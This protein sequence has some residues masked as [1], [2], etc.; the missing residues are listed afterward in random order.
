[1]R[2]FELEEGEAYIVQDDD[3]DENIDPD[4][5]FSYI[6]QKI[7]NVLGQYQKDFMGGLSAE[8][9]GARFGGYGSFLPMQQRSPPILSN[10]RSQNHVSSKSPHDLPSERFHQ[11]PT[12]A[13]NDSLPARSIPASGDQSVETMSE[14]GISSMNNQ[15]RFQNSGEFASNH[16]KKE[17]V[18]H[19]SEK[20]TLK[21]RVKMASENIASLDNSAI[22]SGLGLVMSPSTSP[23]DSPSE[24]D[25][26][27]TGL[28][29]RNLESPSDILKIMTTLPIPENDLLSPLHGSLLYIKG[30]EKNL[31]TGLPGM[32]EALPVNVVHEN[33]YLKGKKETKKDRRSKVKNASKVKKSKHKEAS[34]ER[35][36]NYRAQIQKPVELKENVDHPANTAALSATGSKDNGAFRVTD[37]VSN[38]S[39]NAVGAYTEEKK[40]ASMMSRNAVSKP[41]TVFDRKNEIGYLGE[42]IGN[43]MKPVLVAR[44]KAKEEPSS[45]KKHDAT[46]DGVDAITLRGKTEKDINFV[47]R[48][49]SSTEKK[50]EVG[51]RG[52][53]VK[54]VSKQHNISKDIVKGEVL[55]SAYLIDKNVILVPKSESSTEK[56]NEGRRES[57]VNTLLKEQSRVKDKVKEEPFDSACPLEAVVYSKGSG[58]VETVPK[59][60]DI[61]F[62]SVKDD[63]NDKCNDMSQEMKYEDVETYETIKKKSRSREMTRS[64]TEQGLPSDKENSFSVVKKKTKDSRIG[65]VPAADSPGGCSSAAKHGEVIFK[66]NTPNKSKKADTDLHREMRMD[67]EVVAKANS[68]KKGKEVSS[69]DSVMG[70]SEQETQSFKRKLKDKSSSIK[71]SLA[72]NIGTK[73][74]A[75][76]PGVSCTTE[77]TPVGDM[78]LAENAPM[79]TVED[80]V[81][82]EKC[83]KWRLLPLGMSA[84][85]LTEKIWTCSMVTWLPGMNKCSFSEDETT[86]A[87]RALYVPIYPASVA[88]TD[89]PADLN[90]NASVNVSAGALNVL[91][92]R[93]T[94][95]DSLPS[96]GK[97]KNLMKTEI[98]AARQIGVQDLHIPVKKDHQRLG[99]TRNLK[100]LKKLPQESDSVRKS[101]DGKLSKTVRKRLADNDVY[102][103]PK[104]L[105]R[106]HQPVED[107]DSGALRVPQGLAKGSSKYPLVKAKGRTQGDI[108]SKGVEIHDV[109]GKKRK[110][111]DNEQRVPSAVVPSGKGGHLVNNLDA[112]KNVGIE[113][114]KEKKSKSSNFQGRESS[115]DRGHHKTQS[116]DAKC[117]LGGAG[118]S[119]LHM[120]GRSDNMPMNQYHV[121][122]VSRRTPGNRISSE[123]VLDLGL[124]DNATTSSSSKIS[125]KVKAKVHEVKSSP[126]GSISSSPIKVSKPDPDKGTSKKSV[127]Y[128]EQWLKSGAE[129]A[130]NEFTPHNEGS[131]D[132]KSNLSRYSGILSDAANEDHFG[133]KVSSGRHS[134]THAIDAQPK[135]EDYKDTSGKLDPTH[136]GTSTS[137]QNLVAENQMTM[138][139]K[140]SHLDGTKSEKGKSHVSRIDSEKEVSSN[141]HGVP[142]FE[143][144]SDSNGGR[145]NNVTGKPSRQAA[146]GHV[147]LRESH[148]IGHVSNDIEASSSRKKDSFH[149]AAKTALREATDLKHS[150]N[151]LKVAGSGLESTGIFFQ[152]ALKFLHGASLLEPGN[153]ESRNGE[154]TPDEVYTSTARLC[155]Y[156][157]LEYEKGNDMASAAL[158]YKCMEV[159]YMRVVYCNDLVASRDRQELQMAVRAAPQVES[160][161]SS[162]SDIDNLNQAAIDTV[163]DGHFAMDHRSHIVSAGNRPN[164]VRLL[165][166]TYDINLAMDA[167]RKSQR[168][169]AAAMPVFTQAGN[170]EGISSIKSVLDF[171]FHDVDGLLH[172]VRLAMESIKP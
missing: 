88:L 44:H 150:A 15:F 75:N 80:W 122:R 78:P 100:N 19:N 106:E 26:I 172:L 61:C 5:D 92:S 142:E 123:M 115:A 140:K 109:S 33:I 84:K 114:S 2:K 11:N 134:S 91:P 171:S 83:H 139:P 113:Y 68:R 27:S 7:E 36:S 164:F 103:V 20:N 120:G 28:Q 136:E 153:N 121:D 151:R 154:M 82:C 79:L 149:R 69:K 4:R 144:G 32:G 3:D 50:D 57:A 127:S 90:A 156:C 81:E 112:G 168:A 21:F 25:G 104:K 132:R 42:D 97:R 34:E 41:S 152:A 37:N 48:N 108:T 17:S 85:S 63:E 56:R 12:V 147:S 66:K 107:Y 76:L 73:V 167:S 74:E 46:E 157:A 49:D 128:N 135:F 40:H 117:N 16:Q 105:K 71:T 31:E 163:K 99:E 143:I 47:L 53:E 137:L 98:D 62:L 77:K 133:K 158:A 29:E 9:L 24:N 138:S 96:G 146:V 60:E 145:V 38:A 125:C 10:Q 94:N 89:K 165:D 67:N 159:A 101:G 166:F 148:H 95:I 111:K 43:P 30:M 45:A 70:V 119:K 55:D 160:P 39:V 18:K 141:S 13:A 124:S 58:I 110:L 169:F 86:N 1:M 130:A 116:D 131:K 102:G 126:V 170:E 162:A 51:W 6:D 22:Y 155:E 129:S 87:L 65:G 59:D 72:S 8:S 23:E 35:K 52:D 118:V 93:A 54:K 64:P 161:S 14:L